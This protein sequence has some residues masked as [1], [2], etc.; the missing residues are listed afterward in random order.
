MPVASAMSTAVTPPVA[1]VDCGTNSTRLLIASG[2]GHTLL[3]R[4]EITRL[5]ESV[6]AA[7]RLQTRAIERVANVLRDYR[8]DLERNGVARS[9]AVATSAV[10]DASNAGTFLDA[11][12]A[13]LGIR[14]E[15]LSGEEEGRLSFAGASVGLP[16]PTSS[17]VV[18]DIGGGSTEIAVGRGNMVASTSLDIGCVRLTE[19]HLHD[20]P[21]T[22]AQLT[23]AREAIRKE[24]DKA[25]EI[26]EV[27]QHPGSRCELVGLAGTVATLAALDQSLEILDPSR[28]HHYLLER[29]AVQRWCVTLAAETA[30][31]RGRRPCISPGREDVIVAGALVLTE[32]MD[33]LNASGC[34]VSELDILDGIAGELLR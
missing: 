14:P 13:A 27:A 22:R 9:R 23:A 26:A 34:L 28:F 12:E 30:F 33:H 18:V 20:D 19:R 6:D 25:S 29:D 10:R 8:Q 3:R 2:A 21:P 4:T 1:A 15:I 31:N 5:G 7:K 32:I 17:R 24:L 11:A 16:P